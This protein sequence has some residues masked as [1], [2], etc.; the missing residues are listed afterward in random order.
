[1]NRGLFLFIFCC[2]INSSWAQDVAGPEESMGLPTKDKKSSFGT[3]FEGSPGKAA[4]YSFI[5]PGAGQIYNKRYWKAPLVWAAEGTA[6]YFLIDRMQTYNDWNGCYTSLVNGTDDIRCG[7][8]T[9]VSDAFRIR[10]STRSNLET[11]WLFM[12]L[13][14]VVNALEAFIDRHLINFDTSEDIG[15]HFSQPNDTAGFIFPSY[16]FISIT[17]PLNSR[18]R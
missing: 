5:L 9:E 4:L 1:M 17:I 10:Q 14:H 6:L 18:R 3:V 16:T 12:G 7:T 2:V 13:A 15:F 11:A 8:V